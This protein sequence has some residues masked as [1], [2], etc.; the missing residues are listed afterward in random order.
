MT[1]IDRQFSGTVNNQAQVSGNETETNWNNN[2]DDEPTLIRKEV[3]LTITKTD[4]ADPVVAGGQLTYTLV[5]T[6]NGPSSATSV[7]VTDTLPA[8]LTFVSG[9]STSGTVESRESSCDGRG[10]RSGLRAN[11]HHHAG[12]AGRSAVLRDD[13]QS[14]PP[15]R[16]NETETNPNNNTA[17]QPTVINELRSSISGL[18][19]VD[20]DN[21]G[22]HDTG[23]TA[24]QRHGHCTLRHRFPGLLWSSC[25]TT[26]GADGT[27]PFRRSAPRDVPIERSSSPSTIGTARTPSAAG[28]ANTTVNDEFSNIQL[29]AGTAATDYLFGERPS[30]FSKWRV[31]VLSVQ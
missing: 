27:Y 12:D 29:P 17:L 15:S 9:S 31:P 19:Y 3:D 13:H 16:G 28:A 30:T 22:L 4:S 2:V 23:E 14:R 24:D 18:V 10:G 20:S 26:T 1:T 11:R 8:V 21:D 25:K 7:V 5:V 6:N